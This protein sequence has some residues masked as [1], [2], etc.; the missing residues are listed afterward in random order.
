VAPA[1]L[2]VDLF[3]DNYLMGHPYSAFP[4]IDAQGHPGGLVTANRVKS[5]PPE[6]RASTRLA[7]IA[8]PPEEVP[9]VAPEVPLSALLG[10]MDGCADG[11]ALVW[12]GGYLVGIVT[13]TD[14]R[15]AVQPQG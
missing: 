3:I 13:P 2:S 14:I 1:E 10:R 5:V 4:L 12:H 7:D 8:C 9:S 15:R 11:R 6:E